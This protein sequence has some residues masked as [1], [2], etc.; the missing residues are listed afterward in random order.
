[1]WYCK[2]CRCYVH[3]NEAVT[4]NDAKALCGLG[5]AGLGARGGVW[6]ALAGAL[7][8]ALAGA[9]IDAYVRPKCPVCATVLRA[10]ADDLLG[11]G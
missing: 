5:G 3:D 11:A 1:M 2:S 6:G 8:G 10:V 7:L 4:S 9:V